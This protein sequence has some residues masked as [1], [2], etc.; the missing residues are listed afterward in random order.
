LTTGVIKTLNTSDHFITDVINIDDVYDYTPTALVVIDTT[1]ACGGT[2][3]PG[4]KIGTTGDYGFSPRYCGP[5]SITS[6]TAGKISSTQANIAFGWIDSGNTTWDLKITNVTLGTP[7]LTSTVAIVEGNLNFPL[8]NT[9][10][11][12]V[13]GNQNGAKKS[14]NVVVNSDSKVIYSNF[15]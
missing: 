14:F 3:L 8:D 2:K 1:N 5:F 4:V 15:Y 12:E 13:V 10:L 7:A 9:Q 11:I 6:Y